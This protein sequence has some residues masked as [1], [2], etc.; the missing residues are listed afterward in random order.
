MSNKDMFSQRAKDVMNGAFEKAA[1][2]GHSFIGSEHILFSLACGGGEA[3]ALLNENGLTAQLISDLIAGY[4]GQSTQNGGNMIAITPDAGRVLEIAEKQMSKHGHSEV[5]PEHL[6]LAIFLDL[7]CVANKMI[8][9]SGASTRK[10]SAELLSVQ[11]GWA[12]GRRA[13]KEASK[14]EASTETLDKYSRDLTQMAREGKL[15]PVIGR[16]EEVQRAIQILSRRTKNNPCLIGEPGVGK[17]AIAEG[18]AQQIIAGD[19]PEGLLNCRILS[20]DLASMVAGTKYRGDFEERIKAYIDEACANDNVILFID[21]L[22]TIIGAGATEGAMDAANILKP[23][24]SRGQL[25]VIGATTLGEYRKHIEKDSALER[26]FQSITVQEPTPQQSIEILHGLREKYEEHHGLKI[27]DEAIDSAVEL[28]VRYIQDRYLPDKAIDLMDE[29]ASRVRTAKQN[30]PQHLRDI[31]KKI[32]A[33]ENEKQA[34]IA[35]QDFEQ[36]AYFRDKQGEL[37]TE[38]DARRQSLRGGAAGSVIP[39]DIAQ[40]VS[41]WTGVPV[42]MLTEDESQ[43][44]LRLEET[45]HRRV[46]GQD[47]AVTAV[48]KAIRRSRIGLKDPKRPV[49]S[50][51]FLGPTGVGKTE[52]CKTLAEALFGD[53]NAMVRVDMSEYMERHTVSKLIGSPPGYVGYDEGGQ[54]T[55]KVRR[56]PY[57]VILFDEIE[58]AHPDVWSL[59]LQIMDDGH[60]TDAQGRRVSFK[61]AIIVMTS[62]LGARK[63][64]ERSKTL[65][66]SAN[67]EKDTVRPQEDIKKDIMQELKMAFKP[68]FLNRIDE[69]VV[70][71][72]LQ[73]DHILQ[74]AQLMLDSLGARMEAIGVSISVDDSAR[75]YIANQGFDPV[76]GARP[77]RRVIQREIEDRAAEMLLEAGPGGANLRVLARD[78]RLE[79]ELEAKKQEALEATLTQ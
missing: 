79:I 10:L 61:N 17:T 6:L 30:V 35:A 26:R 14:G 76:Y 54:L 22:H 2:M 3:G 73:Q 77:L 8:T 78:G 59:L 31:E 48:S 40:V 4:D 63:L 74:I 32:A 62:N 37:R 47:D 20:L 43:R 15:D 27:T 1:S 55:E 13:G 66:F 41:S 65:G 57:S 11:E 56:R 46:I 21:E 34:A 60:L 45:L 18:L 72:S 71:H 67:L 39:E 23:A 16:S 50:F 38:L 12:S 19:V 53:E 42:T 29:A 25:Q 33:L 70:F 52:L 51:L 75:Q 64:T 58:K 24:L 49:G 7:E 36:A 69:I 28:S 44:L 5:Y 9:S 68:E